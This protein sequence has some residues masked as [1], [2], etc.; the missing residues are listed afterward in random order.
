MNTD[1]Y[2]NMEVRQ[3]KNIVKQLQFVLQLLQNS[4]IH[5]YLAHSSQMHPFSIPRKHQSRKVFWYFQGVEKVSIGN[6]W[7]D[8]L[9]NVVRVHFD[10]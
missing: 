4:K 1:K 5:C 3:R 7:D 6:E 9:F 8:T 10:L 2:F